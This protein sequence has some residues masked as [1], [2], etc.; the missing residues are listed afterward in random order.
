MELLDLKLNEQNSALIA[1]MTH[2]SLNNV[3]MMEQKRETRAQNT[4]YPHEIKDRTSQQVSDTTDELY[5]YCDANLIPQNMY[6]PIPTSKHKN[7]TFDDIEHHLPSVEFTTDASKVMKCRCG[8]CLLLVYRLF[9][10][11]FF[12]FSYIFFHFFIFNK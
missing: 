12:S 7:V 6:K 8:S 10:F 3:T 4:S 5:S 1:S 9:Y 2:I 11:I